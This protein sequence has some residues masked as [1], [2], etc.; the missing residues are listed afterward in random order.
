VKELIYLA[1][2]VAGA[3]VTIQTAINARLGHLLANSMHAVLVSFTVGTVGALLY[4]LLE[5]GRVAPLDHVKSGPWWAWTGGLLGVAFVWCMIVAVPRVGVSVLFPLV[6]AG[7]MAAAL[8]LEQWGL[9]GSPTQPVTLGRIGGVLLVV[10]GAVV[11][12]LTRNPPPA[13]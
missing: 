9:R 2:L 5:C 1:V 13:G 8:V 11:L 6:V 7:Q 4:C 10:A 12:G 3:A